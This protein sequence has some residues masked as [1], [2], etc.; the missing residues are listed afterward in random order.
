MKKIALFMG[1][2]LLS[3]G[4]FAQKAGD[5]AVGVNV[6]FAPCLEEF[7]DVTNFGVGAKFQYNLTDPIRVE[8]NVNYWLKSEEMGLLDVGANVHYL[9]HVGDKFSVYPL[10]G[11][12][13]V[14]F[15]SG[16]GGFGGYDDDDDDFGFDFDFMRARAY[17]GDDDYDGGSD[18]N[19]FMFN[20][21][22]GVQYALTEKIS[23]GAEIKYQ[24]IKD[25]NRMP[26]SVG[27]TY[28][29]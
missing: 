10:V 12:G 24:F 15:T 8:A 25:F 21:G 17:D 5:M 26:I 20:V 11:L 3:A 6:G 4:A 13:F 16:N 7:M 28:K 18:E 9:F 14:H 1:F 2:A 27:L 23:V 29:F 19:K 22:A